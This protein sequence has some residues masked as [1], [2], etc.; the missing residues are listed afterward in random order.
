MTKRSIILYWLLLLVPTLAIAVAVFQ[1]LGH[2]QER[3]ERQALQSARDRAVAIAETMQITIEAVEDDLAEAL[4]SIPLGRLTET[5]VSW[6][7]TN[8]LVRNAFVWRPKADLLYPV[9]DSSATS[10]ERQ[11]ASRYDGLFSGRIPW[12]TA[13]RKTV[14]PQWWFRRSGDW[15]R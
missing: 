12:Q 5:L 9:R 13:G 1:L 15:A 3:I 7:E 10:E 4:R 8:P 14:G 11:F 2:E 6:Q